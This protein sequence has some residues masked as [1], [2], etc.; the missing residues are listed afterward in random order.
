MAN[1]AIATDTVAD[2]SATTAEPD[3]K[4][5][6]TETPAAAQE[7]T[8]DEKYVQNIQKQAEAA[9]KKAVEEALKKAQ[10]SADDKAAYEKDQAEKALQER[11][12]AITRKELEADAKALLSEK[13]L[14][15]SFL[16]MVVGADEEATKANIESM[17]KEFDAAVQ[18]QV[19]KR[20]VGKTPETGNRTSA[21]DTMKAEIAKHLE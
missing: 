20:L 11:E 7:K 21:T 16:A 4:A 5:P 15:T 8:Y 19:E 13:E 14:P 2:Q 1:E 10:M 12:T 17:K 3:A 18:A 6:G 9:T